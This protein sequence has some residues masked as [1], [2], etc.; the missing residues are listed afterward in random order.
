MRG[1]P[2]RNLNMEERLG[3]LAEVKIPSTDINQEPSFMFNLMSK[4]DMDDFRD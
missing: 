3:L 4:V 1:K 2:I